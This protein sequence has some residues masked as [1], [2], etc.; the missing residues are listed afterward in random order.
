MKKF[1]FLLFIFNFVKAQDTILFHNNEIK[2]VKVNEVG[3]DEIKFK[4]YDNLNGPV[5][6]INKSEIKYI[7][8]AGGLKDS[9]PLSKKQELT[10][11]Q[12]GSFQVIEPKPEKV[13]APACDKI[14]IG[15]KNK[16][17]CNGRPVGESRLGNIILTL[18]EGAKKKSMQS[19]Y[20]IMK[21]Q[22]TQQ[23]IWGYTGLAVGVIG[24]YAG[25]LDGI[26]LLFGETP[27]PQLVAVFVIGG[28]YGIYGAVRSA[29]HKQQRNAAKLKLAKIYNE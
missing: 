3:T 15:P 5:Y 24:A 11:V 29:Q 27:P 25:V 19:M 21:S 16:L 2:I 26:F 10:G 14:I 7:K 20:N 23:Y 9:F 6:V 12:S 1:I 28:A 8:Y 4:R 13:L 17:L 18:P 22:R